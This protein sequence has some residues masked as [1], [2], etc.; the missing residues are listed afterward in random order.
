ML[1]VIILQLIQSQDKILSLSHK[2][3]DAGSLPIDK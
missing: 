1:I 3:V 2:Q